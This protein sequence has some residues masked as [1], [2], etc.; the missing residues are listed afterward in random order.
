MPPIDR[1]QILKLLPMAAGAAALQWSLHRALRGG[2]L[3]ALDWPRYTKEK[4][5]IDALEHV[6][7]FFANGDR[8]KDR[9]GLQ[10][11]P[12]E[13]FAELKTRISD[14][15]MHSVLIMCDG[16]GN[17]GDPDET[18]RT[19]AVEG[20]YAWLDIAK[21]LG[22]HSIRVNAGSDPKLMPEEQA[23]LCADGL[24]RLSEK[25]APMGLG[26]I[27]ENHGGLSSDG[28]WLSTVMRLVGLPNCGTL[29]DFGNFYL[30]KNRGDAAA[31]EQQKALFT[32]R[33][34]KEDEKGLYYDRYQGVTDLM[35]F[36][37]GVSAKTHDF[38]AA[39]E[40]IHTDYAKMMG[41]VAAAGYSG[42]VG[43]EYEGDGLSEDEGVLKTKALLERVLAN[44]S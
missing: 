3:D 15:G 43:I 9:Y 24:H 19:N 21:L 14:L 36:A 20:H 41:I 6:N 17:L 31:Y 27:V 34:A 33:K 30:V 16:V 29:P 37:K 10:P 2:Q 7:Q 12:Q 28:S 22:C 4:F 13:H 40:E 8:D 35:P 11:K 42:H 26:V 32:G 5:G 23:R 25:A 39:G 38:D 18:R 44:L 1:R